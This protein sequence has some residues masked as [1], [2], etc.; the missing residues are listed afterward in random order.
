M[1]VKAI[2]MFVYVLIFPSMNIKDENNGCGEVYDD[3]RYSWS[4][5]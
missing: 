2:I 1:K 4:S 5:I 3:Q